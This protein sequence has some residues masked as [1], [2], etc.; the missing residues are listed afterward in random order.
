M[1]YFMK[2]TQNFL[3]ETESNHEILQPSQLVSKPGIQ[4]RTTSRK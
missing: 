4:N 3:G 1:T 2:L